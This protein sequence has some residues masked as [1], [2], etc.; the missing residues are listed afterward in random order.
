MS[1]HLKLILLSTFFGLPLVSVIQNYSF[2]DLI[3]IYEQIA[4]VLHHVSL[5][6]QILNPVAGAVFLGIFGFLLVVATNHRTHIIAATGWLITFY[7]IFTFMGSLSVLFLFASIILVFLSFAIKWGWIIMD[8][9]DNHSSNSET[10][11]RNQV[12]V[13]FSNVST[14]LQSNTISRLMKS[15]IVTAALNSL[16]TPSLAQ[17]TPSSTPVRTTS[18][19]SNKYIFRALWACLAVNH[20]HQKL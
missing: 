7:T 1:T 2:S 5:V 20:L 9:D 17:E 11:A 15:H 12:N 3:S 10:P 4:E 8:D 19:D 14:P 13:N 16:S 18:S 6:E